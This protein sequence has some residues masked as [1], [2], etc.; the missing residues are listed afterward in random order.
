MR[1]SLF[2]VAAGLCG[3]LGVLLVSGTQSSSQ[4][5]EKGKTMTLRGEII[6]ISCYRSK[7]VKEGTG[8]AHLDCAKKCVSEGKA[9]GLLSE[10]DGLWAL[11][12][13]LTK[14]KNA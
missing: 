5:L 10:G 13:D 1:R 3:A 12:G 6:E 14:D 11:A 8:A 2:T 4:V 9:V 7:G